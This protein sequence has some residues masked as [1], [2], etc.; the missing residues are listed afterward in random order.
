MA[1]LKWTTGF[2]LQ[3]YL[4]TKVQLVRAWGKQQGLRQFLGIVTIGLVSRPL[5]VAEWKGPLKEGGGLS[6]ILI[7]ARGAGA[8]DQGTDNLTFCSSCPLTCWCIL[9]VDPNQNQKTRQLAG[10]GQLSGPRVRRVD[11]G[12]GGISEREVEQ[13]TIK[14]GRNG[15]CPF[16]HVFT[17][18][19]MLS[20]SG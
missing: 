5:W 4:F 8:G 11:C 10:V 17:W 13:S 2:T 1:H 7:L 14:Q 20:A 3:R 12:P 9:I 6:A 15:V 19:L 18:G 16:T